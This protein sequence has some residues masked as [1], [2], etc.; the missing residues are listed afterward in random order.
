MAGE[1][2]TTDF[3]L[4][5]ASVMFG[6]L[7]KVFDLQPDVHGVGLVKNVTVTS[8][9]SYTELTQGVKNSLV[10]SVMTGNPVRAQ[11]E[12]YE[13]TAQNLNYAAGLDG[14]AITFTAA[15]ST[16]ANA[17]IATDPDIDVAAGDGAKF[18][19][20]DW[21][22][23]QDGASDKIYVRKVTAIAL[24][25]LTLHLALPNAIA[26]GATVK[27]SQIIDIGSK[28]NQPFLGCKIVGT[29]AD[30]DSIGLIF[31]KVRITRG[32]NVAFT[33]DNFGNM[34]FELQMYDLVATDALYSEFQNRLGFAVI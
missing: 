3:M 24:D 18:T 17:V 6:P 22:A 19:V 20:G 30:G 26:A 5:T 25:V 16:L 29:L 27:K 13:Y 15:A 10:Y 14:S 8:E 12:V 23:I 21:I 7:D 11:M 1:A 31:P 34:P 9:P 28:A 4:G 32:F 2:K 33:S